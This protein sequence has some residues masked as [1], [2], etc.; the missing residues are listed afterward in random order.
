MSTSARGRRFPI[1]GLATVLGLAACRASP[2]PETPARPAA[3]AIQLE[4]P[5]D[6]RSLGVVAPESLLQ[7]WIYRGGPMARMGHNHVIASHHLEGVVHLTDEPSRTRFDLRIPVNELAIDEPALRE[8]AGADFPPAV[9]QSAREGTRKNLL[10]EALLDGERFPHI[11]LRATDVKPTGDHWDVG[12]D[13]TF[14]ESV[15][16]VRVPVHIERRG[17]GIVARG[18]FTLNQTQ[19]GLK[20]FSV[21]MG[22]LVV[23]DEMRIHFELVAR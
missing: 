22:S 23:L 7:I 14:K 12:V 11:R 19:L 15:Y 20:P 21:A 13:I 2:P 4:I 16:P 3:A 9:P 17:A 6:A 18:H 5:S 10:S 8:A 1:L